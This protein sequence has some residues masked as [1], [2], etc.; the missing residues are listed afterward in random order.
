MLLRKP[1][2]SCRNLKLGVQEFHMKYVVV[3]EDIAAKAL[4]LFDRGTT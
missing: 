4:L 3:P 1:K 2:S